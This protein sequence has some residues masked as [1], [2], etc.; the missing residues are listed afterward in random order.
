MEGQ[1][2]LDKQIGNIPIKVGIL[3]KEQPDNFPFRL[4]K[5]DRIWLEENPWDNGWESMPD[6]GEA[7]G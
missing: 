4:E 7:P 5:Q 1:I 3:G 6:P 2:P